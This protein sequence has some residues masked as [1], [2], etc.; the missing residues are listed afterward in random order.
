M[1]EQFLGAR[2][3]VRIVLLYR[4]VTGYI[5]WRNRFLGIASCLGN[6]SP[7][8]GARKVGIGLSYQPASLCSFPR[9]LQTLF[10][11]SIPRPKAGLK[12]STLGSLNVYKFGLRFCAKP[13]LS[14]LPPRHILYLQ[15]SQCLF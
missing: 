7:A 4:P 9:Q 14:Y 15:C 6:L 5:G 3:Q 10:L 11:E 13:Y 12:F 1:L 8:M 2:K